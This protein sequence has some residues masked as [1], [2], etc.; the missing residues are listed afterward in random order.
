[1]L[2]YNTVP[3]P[4]MADGLQRYMEH[5]IQG[6]SFLHAMLCGDFF[7]M[8]RTADDKNQRHLW[9]WAVWFHNEAPIESFGSPKAVVGWQLGRQK[10]MTKTDPA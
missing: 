8:C 7:E 2:N 9:E 4:Y 3:V 6:G 10:A 5:G 1:M